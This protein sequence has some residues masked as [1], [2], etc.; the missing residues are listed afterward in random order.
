[1]SLTGLRVDDLI[2]P[3]DEGDEDYR[4]ARDAPKKEFN[5][6]HWTSDAAGEPEFCGNR[7]TRYDESWSWKLQQEEYLK[8]IK[9]MTTVK[10]AAD[11]EL[12]PNEVSA[13]RGLV[14]AL[15]WASTQSS[16]HLS[17]TVSLLCGSVSGATQSVTEG[18]NKALR[19]AK[20]NADASLRFQRLGPLSDLCLIAISDAAWGVRQDHLSQGGFFALLAHKK[21]EGEMDQPYVILEWRSYNSQKFR[22]VR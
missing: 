17:A 6:K 7:L 4:K 20:A 18:A 5:F 1:M 2:A 19:F 12:R 11:V 15:Q 22:E 14:G 9:P 16:P 21:I 8:K 10:K 13:L 3:G